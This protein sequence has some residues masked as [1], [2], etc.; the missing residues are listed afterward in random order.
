VLSVS[1][2]LWFT[3]ISLRTLIVFAAFLLVVRRT[4]GS[5]LFPF[6][7]HRSHSTW[8]GWEFFTSTLCNPDQNVGK[9]VSGWEF[10]YPLMKL[11]SEVEVVCQ[12]TS[13]R[14]LVE[15]TRTVG[16]RL[17]RIKSTTPSVWFRRFVPPQFLSSPF[18][19]PI[20]FSSRLLPRL[21]CLISISC[22]L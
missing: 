4:Y 9:R 21:V 20:N 1:L 22:Q 14:L 12:V 8:L 10:G 2:F 7:P 17:S 6:P 13:Q 15:P 11:V 16:L 19:Q 5:A 3:Q 18:I